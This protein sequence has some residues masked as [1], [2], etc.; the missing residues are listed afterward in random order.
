MG[1]PLNTFK[2]YTANVSTLLDTI[3][4]T[5][6]GYTTVI[7]LAQ[8]TNINET[9]VVKVSGYHVRNSNPTALIKNASVPV[10]DAINILTGKLVLET[11]DRISVSADID[12]SAQI[13]L[14]VLE[15]ANP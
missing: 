13:I 2:T 15:T 7:L 4:T 6:P 5:P 10:S 14:S 9:D 12:D 1:A 8:V 11:G 3:Y